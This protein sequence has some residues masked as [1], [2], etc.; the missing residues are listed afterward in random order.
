MSRMVKSKVL[1]FCNTSLGKQPYRL[2]SLSNVNALYT[3]GPSGE[4]EPPVTFP[5]QLP[6]G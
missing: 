6:T 5:A 2:P 1:A 4:Y 3:C